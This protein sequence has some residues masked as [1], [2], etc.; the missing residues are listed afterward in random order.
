[1]PGRR[2]ISLN[3]HSRQRRCASS[4]NSSFSRRVYLPMKKDLRRFAEPHME[5]FANARNPVVAQARS[6]PQRFGWITVARSVQPL[7]QTA[8]TSAHP[9]IGVGAGDSFFL[10]EKS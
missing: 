3:A 8:V 4:L 2:S 9:L 1:M 10:P 6:S 7:L 5:T